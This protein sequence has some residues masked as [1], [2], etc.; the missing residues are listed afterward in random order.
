MSSAPPSPAL[1]HRDGAGCEPTA[2]IVGSEPR[3]LVTVARSLR[4]AGVRCVIATP[5]G[6]SLEVRSRAFANVVR[7]RGDVAECASTLSRVARTV[8][9]RWVVPTSDSSL[10]IVCAAYDDLSRFCAVGAPPPAIVQRVLDK[11]ITLATA[12]ACG[13]PVPVSTTIERSSGLEPAL[14][15]MRFP[16]SAKPLDKSRASSQYFSTR[17]FE[18]AE[19][20]R[21]PLARRTRFCEL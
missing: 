14:A 11:A 6:R 7:L 2:I 21:C 15:Q 20:L 9:A 3:K 5:P 17:S 13:V 1:S 18:V 10:Q 8:G 16:I 19:D 12:Q 4:R